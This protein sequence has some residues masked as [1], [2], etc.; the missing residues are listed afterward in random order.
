MNNMLK[1][2]MNA[3]ERREEIRR[4]RIENISNKNNQSNK[5]ISE[6]D[7]S[8]VIEKEVKEKSDIREE[9]LDRVSDIL[10]IEKSNAQKELQYILRFL[11]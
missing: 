3:K 11:Y 2:K 5:V 9:T 1:K 8:D 7:L 4:K 10:N 6:R